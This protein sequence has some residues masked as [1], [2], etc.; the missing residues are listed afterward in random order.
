MSSPRLQSIRRLAEKNQM[1]IEN[2]V[3]ETY[4]AL[5]RDQKNFAMFDG[6][7]HKALHTI[8]MLRVPGCEKVYSVEADPDTAQ[9]FLTKLAERSQGERDRVTFVNKALQGDPSCTSIPWLSST[10]HAGRSSVVTSNA[11]QPTIWA[12]TDNMEYREQTHVEATTIDIILADEKRDIPFVKLDL[13]GADLV[14]LRGGAATMRRCRPTIVFE[15]S[16]HAPSVHGFSLDDMAQYF[17]G[18]DYQ[19]MNFVGEP[20]TPSN[21]FG[22]YEAWVV[23]KE[24]LGTFDTALQAA[25]RRR[26][27]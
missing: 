9:V 17:E 26:D 12:R 8:R 21:W 14:A 22:F 5:C 13:E 16:V 11:A 10:S 15:N 3:S 18:L 1:E 27:I 25:L 19:P 24:H 6:G 7:A 2:V 20:I 23:P 4:T